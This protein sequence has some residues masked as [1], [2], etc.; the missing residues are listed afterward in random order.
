MPKHTLMQS[1]RRQF[2]DSYTS[3]FAFVVRRAYNYSRRRQTL[4]W[5]V[6]EAGGR[7]TKTLRTSK[8]LPHA[9]VNNR[10]GR[11]QRSLRAGARLLLALSFNWY[12]AGIIEDITE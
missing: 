12:C 10:V 8:T 11:S 2:Y 4:R 9:H 3:S 5:I 1:R 7:G 6:D